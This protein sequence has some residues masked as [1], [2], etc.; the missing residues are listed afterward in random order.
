M[1]KTI[2]ILAHVDA[3]KTTFSEQ[4]LF[5]V[6]S[7]ARP[8]RVD[9]QDAFLDSHPIERERGITVFSD[10]A[11]FDYGEN[12]YFLVDTPGHVDFSAEMERAVQ[13]LDYA[14][15]VVS[16]VEGV[17]SHTETVWRLTR[18]YGIPVFFFLNK[19]DR[20]GADPQRVR[21][22][23]ARKLTED[24]VDF[25]GWESG[26]SAWIEELAQ[27]DEDLMDRYFAQG[28]DAETW[29][30]AAVRLIRSGRVFPCFAGSA[31]LDVGVEEFWKAFDRLTET[32]YA[33][34]ESESLAGRVYKVRH[35]AGGNRLTYVKLLAG[36]LSV[37]DVV[38]YTQRGRLGAGEEKIHGLYSCHGTRLTPLS[39]A[40]AG[41]L[42][43]VLGLHGAAPGD[44]I[45]T[46]KDSL[47]YA[48]A[49]MLSAK[50]LC[51][52]KV[53]AKHVLEVFRLLEDEEPM[54][55]V[56]WEEQL[57]E[58][59][60]QIM[61]PIQLEVLKEV[62]R[63]RYGMQVDFGECQVLYKETLAQS[64]QGCGHFEPLRHYAEVHLRLDPL[65]RGSGIQFAS[66]CS[67][68]ALD[69]NYQ[70]LIRTHVLEKEHK[71]VLLGAPLT[72]VR[73]TL[74]M[75]RAH[76]KH[77][78][79]GDFREAT[80]RAI[81]Q[82]LMSAESVVLE[83]IMAFFIQAPHDAMGRILTDIQRM[84]GSFDPPELADAQ[85][86]VTGRAPVAAMM[87]YPQELVAFTKGKGS[88][89]TRFAGYALCH[90][91]QEVIAARGYNPAH[92][93][94][95]P[96]DSVFCAKGAGFTVPWNEA[97]RYMHCTP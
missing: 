69:A 83:P 61:G 79:G 81:R 3:G 37:K 47:P 91:A 53:T 33:Q 65:P 20:P 30:Q 31:L 57:Q 36:T 60:V 85:V 24:A 77:T 46:Q 95:N 34:R 87:H 64:A 94:A 70:N 75:G 48:M 5:H 62:V 15:I 88:M 28:F 41:D 89:S 2:G 84:H 1:K 29:R 19:T 7:L 50:V 8:G 12:R 68:D 52:P 42:C 38:A 39:Q 73:I 76:L 66:E 44:G 40:K 78:E 10:Q 11:V 21:E 9:H 96:A 16:C 58:I 63:T 82:G 72:D 14:I 25:A 23:I 26:P 93:T 90:N 56:R 67:L 74:L 22:E 80:Y 71:G 18:R 51:D 86:R 92:D 27:R 45:G 55:T 97:P 32:D 6:H 17:Q 54:L 43:V 59:Q 49:P 35:D 13:V 4:V